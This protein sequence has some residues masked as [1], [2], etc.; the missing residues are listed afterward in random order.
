MLVLLGGEPHLDKEQFIL[1]GVES[2]GWT[3]DSN[4]VLLGV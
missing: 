1:L 2:F 4:M 3:Q